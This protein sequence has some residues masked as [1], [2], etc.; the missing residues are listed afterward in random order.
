MYLNSK[1]PYLTPNEIADWR[2]TLDVFK[3]DLGKI[4]SKKQGALKN[5]IRCI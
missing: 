2:I 1:I 5:N 3:Y 4:I